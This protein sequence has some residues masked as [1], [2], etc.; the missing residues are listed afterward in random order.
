MMFGN[1]TPKNLYKSLFKKDIDKII[2]GDTHNDPDE[3]GSLSKVHIFIFSVGS[4]LVAVSFWQ[5]VLAQANFIKDWREWINSSSKQSGKEEEA[6][7]ESKLNCISRECPAAGCILE[8]IERFPASARVEELRIRAA[9]ADASPRCIK[10]LS[11]RERRLADLRSEAGNWLK[12]DRVEY[13]S[14]LP[15]LKAVAKDEI[16]SG[17]D[18]DAL[19]TLKGALEVLKWRDIGLNSTTKTTLPIKVVKHGTDD[20]L[21]RAS[22]MLEKNLKN[23]LF[24]IVTNYCD[25]ALI[26]DIH[27]AKPNISIE[28]GGIF[29]STT[30]FNVNASWVGG[31]IPLFDLPVSE[32]RDSGGL[33]DDALSSGGRDA[34][35]R[36]FNAAIESATGLFLDRVKPQ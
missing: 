3:V 11:A 32:T 34:E 24:N 21:G 9:Q 35:T 27:S 25:A 13:H 6:S 4:F 12:R 18:L 33:S 10:P 36:S 22:R 23:K 15:A 19:N 14:F 26:I 29:H 8:F 7:F 20:I 17:D 31:G 16:I 1:D 5:L 28:D 30:S 2:A